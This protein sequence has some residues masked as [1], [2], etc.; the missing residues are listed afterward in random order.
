MRKNARSS[1]APGSTKSGARRNSIDM[2]KYLFG[3]FALAAVLYLACLEF[4]T[5]L[6]E[7]KHA[8]Q[9]L[10]IYSDE[11]FPANIRE[12]SESVRERISR[13]AHFRPQRT[14]R[15]Y[16]SH[17]AWRW[18]LLSGLRDEL[19]GLNYCMFRNNS[20]IRPSVIS[21]NRI[22]P[23]GSW[24]ADAEER[25]LVYF[26]SHE[27]AHGMMRDETGLAAYYLS[28]PNWLE[29]GF[30]DYTAKRSFDFAN[31]LEEFKTGQKR[32]SKASALYVRFHL[33]VAYLI[34]IRG[35]SI[36]DLLAQPPEEPQIVAELRAFEPK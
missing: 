16:I 35:R 33:Y 2:L 10:E 29:E 32:L 27:I 5:F 30:A 21:E 19:G 20:F 34:D 4:P 8:N 18:R 6:F 24:L 31:N 1:P 25:D 15:V 11:P 28:T 22:I 7:F 26:I 36:A 12:L 23:P 3:L 14:Y 13:S 9:S 17:E